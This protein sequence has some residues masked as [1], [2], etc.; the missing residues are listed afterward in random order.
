M[1]I[2]RVKQFSDRGKIADLSERHVDNDILPSSEEIR[3]KKLYEYAQYSKDNN[4]L[5]VLGFITTNYIEDKN[6]LP[7]SVYRLRKIVED[8]AIK[9][10]GNVERMRNELLDC[11]GSAIVKEASYR[12]SPVFRRVS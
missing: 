8:I 12:K 10:N 6:A 2:R 3:L 11:F 7:L 1:S 4:L 9:S 5:S